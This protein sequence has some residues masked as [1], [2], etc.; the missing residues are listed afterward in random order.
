MKLSPHLMRRHRALMAILAAEEP[1]AVITVPGEI[2]RV[3]N[4]G[5]GR[6]R[7]AQ[8]GKRRVQRDLKG[9]GRSVGMQLDLQ[10]LYIDHGPIIV[11]LVRVMPKATM[12]ADN[13]ESAMKRVRDGIAEVIGVDDRDEAI[14]YVP[15][16]RRG[17]PKQE[18][19]LVE[20][21]RQIERP[22]EETKKP[23]RVRK[24]V[25]ETFAT[26]GGRL[27]RVTP[28]VRRAR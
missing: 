16:Q 26:V 17:A 2:Q 6:S 3:V 7:R 1:L 5:E 4:V 15:D 22:P 24:P 9:R 8:N 12:D 21:Y 20:V 28:N 13:L 14:E 25:N 11:V 23:R 19:L 18:A 27:V 10:K